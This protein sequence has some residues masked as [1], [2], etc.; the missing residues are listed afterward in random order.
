M[1]STSNLR[2]FGYENESVNGTNIKDQGFD[3]NYN[4]DYADLNVF[5]N[6]TTNYQRLSKSD[7]LNIL[8]IPSSPRTLEER[9]VAELSNSRDMDM[10]VNA[11]MNMEVVP[12]HRTPTPYPRYENI[13][14]QESPII[15]SLR[16]SPMIQPNPR[17]LSK[18]SSRLANTSKKS[19]L[20]S[21][22]SNKTNSRSKTNFRSKTKTKTN[23]RS[24]LFNTTRRSKSNPKSSSRVASIDRTIY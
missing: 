10:D 14:I 15:S 17:L 7:V 11:D 4:G 13:D 1:E 12:F 2:L 22:S 21:K 8:G 5:S 16:N 18:Q 9:L 24:K 23:S 20:R 19:K 3:L 6:G